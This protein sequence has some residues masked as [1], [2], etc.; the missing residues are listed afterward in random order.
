MKNTTLGIL[1]IVLLSPYLH[2]QTPIHNRNYINYMTDP[3]HY[4][5]KGKGEL[6]TEVRSLN[7]DINE[8]V[9]GN[10][11]QVYI[12]PGAKP[13]FTME[14][15][16]NLL[17]LISSEQVGQKLVLRLTAS[18]ETTRGIKFYIPI[19]SINKFRVK[20]GAALKMDSTL[21]MPFLDI[22][23]DSGAYGDCMI[24]AD[25]FTCL[26]AAGSELI[27]DGTANNLDLFVKGGS[28]LYGKLLKAQNCNATV[29]GASECSIQVED[30]LKARVE[31]ESNLYYFGKPKRINEITKLNGKIEQKA[32]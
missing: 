9:V 31:N 17:P 4:K 12:I 30:T 21:R 23:L 14:A 8:I 11:I 18:L 13:S 25:K 26:V 20:E 7:A 3:T 28:T 15:Q 10:G 32:F 19:G 24:D 5:E 22:A 27:L 1:A 16:E 6:T 2:G 29:L